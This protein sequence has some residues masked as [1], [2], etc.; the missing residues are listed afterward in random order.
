ML[1]GC[2][3]GTRGSRAALTY[4]LRFDRS[5]ITGQNIWMPRAAAT[6][7]VGPGTRLSLGFGQYSQFPDFQQF[8][9]AVSQPLPEA[10]GEL[11]PVGPHRAKMVQTSNTVMMNPIQG[12]GIQQPSPNLMSPEERERQAEIARIIAENRPKPAPADAVASQDELLSRIAQLEQER[13]AKVPANDYSAEEAEIE[14]M[15][16]AEEAAALELSG[17]A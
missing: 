16:A 13:D 4:G 7:G 14:R 1:R 10:V 17:S 3:T 11:P 12:S 6:L 9:G 2:W 5:D 15:I 8:F